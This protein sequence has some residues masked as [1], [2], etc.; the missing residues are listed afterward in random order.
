MGCCS[1]SVYR[2]WKLWTSLQVSRRG[3]YSI[4]R[5]LALQHYSQKCS[6]AR[7]LLVCLLSP[8]LS[9]GSILFLQW[10][11]LE[12]PTQSTLWT[13]WAWWIRVFVM[14]CGLTFALLIQ[15][16]SFAPRLLLTLPERL[17]IA[18]AEGSGF[19]AFVAIVG[20]LWVFPVPFTLALSAFQ[21]VPLFFVL[22]Q[23]VLG[24]KRLRSEESR[25]R[26][27]SALFMAEVSLV[28]IYSIYGTLVASIRSDYQG[29]LVMALPIVKLIMKNAIAGLCH[30]FEDLAP[31]TIVLSVELFDALFTNV[32][33]QSARSWL[34]TGLVSSVYVLQSGITLY[35]L[36][37]RISTV[38]SM[39]QGHHLELAGDLLPLAIALCHSPAP[40]NKVQFALIRLRASHPQPIPQEYEAKLLVLEALNVYNHSTESR[41]MITALNAVSLTAQPTV[42]PA[43][44]RSSIQIF[45]LQ[46]SSPEKIAKSTA[47][48]LLL[49]I[50]QLIYQC[51]YLVLSQYVQ[52]I[53]TV[54]WA[55]QHAE[56]VHISNARFYLTTITGNSLPWTAALYPILVLC[57]TLALHRMIRSRLRLSVLNILSFVLET[58]AELVQSRLMFWTLV[59]AQFSLQH[60]GKMTSFAKHEAAEWLTTACFCVVGVDFTLKFEWIRG[61]T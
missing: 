25:L 43:R 2:A 10:L 23:I 58:Q 55:V 38:Q 17:Q 39:L 21:Q 19:A 60:F 41:V 46:L 40:G 12:I 7:L 1:A 15:L 11:P 47:P 36:S 53:T 37:Q 26:V 3:L 18:V 28:F 51:E 50:L 34:T 56:L 45:P 22:I 14:G 61:K 29:L 54:S 5:L 13:D 33:M 9:L 6:R 57:S 8:L 31:V 32:C 4:E 59:L 30:H 35:M 48:E 44:R 42:V 49:A 20:S 16:K 27:F 52:S 24:S